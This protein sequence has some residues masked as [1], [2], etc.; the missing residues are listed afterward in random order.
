VATVKIESGVD[1]E[2]TPITKEGTGKFVDTASQED[3][4]VEG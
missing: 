2:D 4:A 3:E 1:P